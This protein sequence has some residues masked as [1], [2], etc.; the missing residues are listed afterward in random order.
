[1]AEVEDEV[2]QALDDYEEACDEAYHEEEEEEPWDQENSESSS[3]E[4]DFPEPLQL[5]AVYASSQEAQVG[6]QEI[7]TT[8]EGTTPAEMGTQATSSVSSNFTLST[9]PLLL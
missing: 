2:W 3:S 1:M 4:E 5:L 7:Q 6:S 9:S 8:L